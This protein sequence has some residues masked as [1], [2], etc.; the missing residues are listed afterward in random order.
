MFDHN[1]NITTDH[2]EVL[3]Q[4]APRLVPVLPLASPGFTLD[5][6]A[7]NNPSGLDCEMIL[8]VAF[9]LSPW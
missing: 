4:L 3:D 7:S 5:P 1:C 9:E 2:L 8:P 6:S